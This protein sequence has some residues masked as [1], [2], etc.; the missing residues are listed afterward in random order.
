MV[1]TRSANKLIGKPP[2]KPLPKKRKGPVKKRP[3]PTPPPVESDES[4][5]SSSDGEYEASDEVSG[6]TLGT[7]DS[8]ADESVDASAD[9][10]VADDFVDRDEDDL[11]DAQNAL[12]DA[13]KTLRIALSKIAGKRGRVVTD[14][15]D[16]TGDTTGENIFLSMLDDGEYA[17]DESDDNSSDMDLS[18][19]ERERLREISHRLKPK[20][21][22]SMR[23]R[24]LTS[25]YDDS[26]KAYI[27]SKYKSLKQM[28]DSTPEYS[29][30]KNWLECVVDLSECK[31]IP[32][33]ITKDLGPKAID[34]SLCAIKEGFDTDIY[35]QNE[36]KEEIINF[37]CKTITNPNSGGKILAL[38]GPKGCGKTTFVHSLS[39]HLNVP[40]RTIPLGGAKCSDLLDGHGFTYEGAIPGRLAS[41]LRE[42]QCKNPIIFLDEV[43]KISKTERGDEITNVLLHII[44]ESQNSTF[45]DK[46]L[47]EVPVDLSKVFFIFAFNDFSEMNK[48]LRDRLHI[49]NIKQPTFSEKVQICKNYLVK[50]IEKK[51]GFKEGDIIFEEDQIKYLLNKSRIKEEGVRQA[52]R[53]ID[54]MF[55]RLN[56]LRCIMGDDGS[57]KDYKLQVPYNL[58]NFKLPFHITNHIID[59]L[60]KEYQDD[61]KKPPPMMYT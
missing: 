37:M 27:Y 43:D 39:K 40:F 20:Q 10:Y 2:A 35:N 47:G 8:F 50:K 59:S 26:L 46:F 28:D 24:V 33:E 3:P 19:T 58:P 9:T 30:L 22:K 31:I 49:I 16:D 11:A 21:T 13:K 6:D 53:N 14:E 44:D 48:Y 4:D 55:E 56:V 29:K 1:K 5:A 7:E 34:E 23:A 12:E 41:I 17:L 61:E 54:V 18:D 36:A 15:D 57:N 25:N 32:N 52:A 45:H 60:F 51:Y 38:Q 42:T